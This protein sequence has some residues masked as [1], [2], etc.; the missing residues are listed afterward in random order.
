MLQGQIRLPRPEPA[1]LKAPLRERRVLRLHSLY[2]G[3]RLS[4]RALWCSCCGPQAGRLVL[5]RAGR[6]SVPRAGRIVAPR[7]EWEVLLL[8]R[9]LR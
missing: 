1:L 4:R 8:M 3:G 6:V 9:S 7:A 5:P 2:A